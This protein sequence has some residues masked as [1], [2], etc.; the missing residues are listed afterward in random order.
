MI[1]AAT[2]G[3]ITSYS[4]RFSLASMTGKFT[5][6]VQAALGQISGTDGPTN[7]NQVAQVAGEARQAPAAYDVAYTLQTGPTRFAPMPPLPGTVITAK[8]AGPQ[9]PQS[10]YSVYVTFAGQPN[11][12]TTQTLQ[13]TYSFSSIENTVSAAP[14]PT[15]TA[16]QKFLNRW[17]D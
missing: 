16:M 8:N 15:D 5:P 10:S 17:K 14:Q 12:A 13:P 6:P 4:K 11:A 2:G 9:F 7:V 1:G 3:T